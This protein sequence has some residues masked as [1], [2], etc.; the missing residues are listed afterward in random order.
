M[1]FAS[2]YQ[3]PTVGADVCGFNLNT[4]ST[5]CSRWASLGAFYPFY[6]NHADITSA[7]QEFYLWPLVAETA[8]KSIR[9]RM[10]LMDY[11]YTEFHYQ[12]VDGLPRTILPLF[13]VYPSDPNTL[14]IELQFFYG[15][16]L[17]ISPVTEE[18]ST[19]VSY[20]L[21]KDTFYDFFSGEKV[22]G[23]GETVSRDNVDYTEIPVHV[24]G[25][26]IIPMRVDGANNTK[27]LRELDFELLIAPDAD[28]NAS[29]RLYLDDGESLNPSETSEISFEYNAAD[30][31]L[32][33]KG[34]F[35]YQ[36]SSKIQ[37]A[38]LLG[39]L[40]NSASTGSRK[41][42]LVDL[43][44]PLSGPFTASLG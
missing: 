33:A 14:E 27:L 36:T 24:R 30:H 5:L 7:R 11:F 20:Y 38:T 29:G 4:T 43:G 12:T 25:G 17:L 2:I 39:S 42:K 16:S 13:Y 6:R 26:S 15:P 41:G 21:P 31:T 35:E 34:T 19:S 23:Q 3:I 22:E 37:R 1:E 32:V 10:Q 9:T 18:N 40:D 8:R 28:G 44:K